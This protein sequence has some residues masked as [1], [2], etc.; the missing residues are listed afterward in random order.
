MRAPGKSANTDVECA[1]VNKHQH[2][3][4]MCLQV[5]LH[6][7][8]GERQAGYHFQSFRYSD[9]A[10]GGTIAKKPDSGLAHPPTADPPDI[11]LRKYLLQSGGEV[12]SLEIARGLA[13][14]DHYARGVLGHLLAMLELSA[15]ESE[16]YASH[17]LEQIIALRAGLDFVLYCL[18]GLGQVEVRAI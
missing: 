4:G 1:E 6:L 15:R 2:V 7:P 18:D 8:K 3:G 10:P 17:K 16:L 11:S 13:G 5:G 12:R 9:G 14:D